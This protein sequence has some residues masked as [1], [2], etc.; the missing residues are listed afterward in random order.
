MGTGVFGYQNQ[1]D[2]LRIWLDGAK[3]ENAALQKLLSL[4]PLPGGTPL[5]PNQGRNLTGWFDLSLLPPFE[6]MSKYFSFLVYSLTATSHGFGG[7]LFMPLP[8][9]LRN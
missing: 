9:E 1:A 4:A 5:A 6:R 3:N 8:P 7:K 2:T